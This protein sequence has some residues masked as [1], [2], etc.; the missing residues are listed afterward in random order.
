MAGNPD[1]L[2][3]IGGTD[4]TEGI[5]ASPVLPE[6]LGGVV[7]FGIS[8]SLG[9]SLGGIV[10]GG[11]TGAMGVIGV[12]QGL[13]TGPHSHEDFLQQPALILSSRLGR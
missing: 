6:V 11:V 4:G 5:G 13:A 12:A 10:V 9:I 8:F 7:V 3:A 1:G 2:G